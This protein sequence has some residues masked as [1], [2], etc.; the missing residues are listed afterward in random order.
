MSEVCK[1][2]HVKGSHGYTGYSNN[3]EGDLG[4]GLCRVCDDNEDL[5]NPCKKFR[6]INERGTKE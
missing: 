5:E 3:P 6:K 1:C 2:G 4:K